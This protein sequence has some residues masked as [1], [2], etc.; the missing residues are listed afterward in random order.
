MAGKG[1]RNMGCSS[2]SEGLPPVCFPHMGLWLFSFLKHTPSLWMTGW[3][4]KRW[5]GLIKS[6]CTQCSTSFQ[7][8]E[9]SQCSLGL[10]MWGQVWCARVCVHV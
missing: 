8:K 5:V 9:Q 6:H 10:W 4:V 1:T 2:V 7:S 3:P